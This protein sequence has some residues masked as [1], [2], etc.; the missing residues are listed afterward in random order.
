LWQLEF[1]KRRKRKGKREEKREE[2]MGKDEK[3][4]FQ[5]EGQNSSK[6]THFVSKRDYNEHYT[7]PKEDG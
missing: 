2:K 6:V 3:I 1:E 4:R 7:S 5:V